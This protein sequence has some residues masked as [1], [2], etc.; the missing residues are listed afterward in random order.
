MLLKNILTAHWIFIVLGAIFI[1]IA[2]MLITHRIA[3]PLF[4]LERTLER[5]LRRDLSDVIYLRNRDEGKELAKKINTFNKELSETFKKLTIHSSAVKTL[6]EQVAAE[7][8]DLPEDQKK[9]LKAVLWNIEENN[10]KIQT[11]CS[12]YTLREE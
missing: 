3:G 6:L 1:T 7:S 8:S 11:I 4:R 9:N 12:S 10:K 5:M 2:A